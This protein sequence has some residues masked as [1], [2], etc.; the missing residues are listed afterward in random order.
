MSGQGEWD[1]VNHYNTKKQELCVR[2]S[3]AFLACEVYVRYGL[4]E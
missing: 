2:V 4:Q 3:E 1:A